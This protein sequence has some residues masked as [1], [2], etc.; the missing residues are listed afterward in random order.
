MKRLRII[1]ILSTFILFHCA[2]PN[3]ISSDYD[4]S[5]NFDS[6]STFVVCV[7]DY[8]VENP[9]YPNYDNKEV[10]QL[11]GDEI[12]VQMEQRGHQTNVIKPQLQAGFKILLRNEE[13][14]FSN[15]DEQTEYEYWDT[16]TINKEVY[17]QETL[18]LYVSDINKNQ[19]IWQAMIDCDLNKPN[20]ELRKYISQ[21][22]AVIFKEYP[23]KRHMN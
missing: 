12:A 13:V 18:V 7:D 15:C 16:C 4:E 5:I 10:R 2:A 3:H 14:V 19:V 20:K 11:I 6:Y 8:F 17:T 9:S 21:L 22:V 1:T 23:T